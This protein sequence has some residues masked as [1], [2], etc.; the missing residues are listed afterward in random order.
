MTTIDLTLLRQKPKKYQVDK[1]DVLGIYVEGV[2]GKDGEMPPIYEP[3]T[4]SDG[5][6]SLGYPIRVRENGTISLPWLA[7]PMV[8]RGMSIA[9]VEEAVRFAYT[10]RH[11]LVKP[12]QARIMVTLQKPRTYDVMVVR[13][14]A[15]AS[16][17]AGDDGAG[18]VKVGSAK[19][20]NG[21]AL[22]LPAYKNDVLNAL[23]QTGGLPGLDA[24]NTIYVLHNRARPQPVHNAA[25]GWSEPLED[26][27]PTI[28]SEYITKIPVKLS[29]GELPCFGEEDIILGDGDV[30]FIE[31][32]DT[33]VYYTGGLLGGGQYTLPRDYDLDVFEAISI[34][35]GVT[36]LGRTSPRGIGG[37]SSLNQD[38]TV[39]ASD[40]IILRRTPHGGHIPIKVNL[41]HAIKH[42]EER[43][44]I[45]PGDYI[46]LRYTPAESVAAFIGRHLLD[47]ATIGLAA[48]ILRLNLNTAPNQ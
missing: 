24:D 34:A 30:V 35:Q 43:L 9:E 22:K 12:D 3:T 19:R 10:Q 8:V 42:P 29:P 15:G 37:I 11:R 23:V 18:A 7:Q 38:V 27:D 17:V 1:G 31:S 26:I 28:E 39:G 45:K 5:S 21:R 25:E 47:V 40:V 41:Y 32:R 14:E 13:Q 6:P 4:G 20:G 33:E 36:G 48:T 2:F 46:L 44:I 16:D